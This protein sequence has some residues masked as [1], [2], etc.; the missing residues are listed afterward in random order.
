MPSHLVDSVEVSMPCHR[1]SC[2]RSHQI[3]ASAKQDSD[4]TGHAQAIKTPLP[5]L[6]R[7]RA[8][9]R[10]ASQLQLQKSHDK[11]HIKSLVLQNVNMLRVNKHK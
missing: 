4:T 9:L 1:L 5:A 10:H 2:K 8:S 11:V 6:A 7:S 3:A